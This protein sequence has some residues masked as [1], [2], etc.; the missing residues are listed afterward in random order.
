MLL[1]YL[2]DHHIALNAIFCSIVT[3]LKLHIDTF[4]VHIGTLYV[5]LG[6][7]Y[8]HIGTVYPH[9]GTVYPHI[10]TV[11]VHMGPATAS[12]CLSACCVGTENIFKSNYFHSKFQQKKS[13][14]KNSGLIVMIHC[15]KRKSFT[16]LDYV[17]GGTELACTISI[18]FTASNGSPNNP[19]SLH[20]YS[21]YGGT[22]NQ[23]EMAIRAVGD[24]IEDYDS[25]KLFPVL[26]STLLL[27]L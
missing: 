26:G 6:T 7:V 18:D 3:Y 5:H 13:K 11:N 17:Q 21:P 1:H 25:D 23:Y 24:I 10:G 22:V 27:F 20:F 16:F 2:R 15:E 8:P 4:Y 12:F 14:Y 9:I 19:D